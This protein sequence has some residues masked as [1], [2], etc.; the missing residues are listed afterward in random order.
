MLTY[1]YVNQFVIF[2]QN[3]SLDQ[4]STRIYVSDHP[5]L[6]P[7][8]IPLLSF[9]PLPPLFF[10]D[11]LL[12]HFRQSSHFPILLSVLFSSPHFPSSSLPCLLLPLK[13]SASPIQSKDAPH[14]PLKSLAH[15][16]SASIIFPG[17]GVRCRFLS[18]VSRPLP[19]TA[20]PRLPA[21]LL[22]PK[23]LFPDTAKLIDTH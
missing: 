16:K 21:S 19:L 22:S 20:S 6:L 10:M 11:S 1:F 12:L 3:S 2:P 13:P 5:S 17:K 23:L 9:P 18:V 7:F 15:H 8:F 14:S 4:T